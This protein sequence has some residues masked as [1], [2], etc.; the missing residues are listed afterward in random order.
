MKD[1]E[2]LFIQTNGIET[3]FHTKKIQSQVNV[4]HHRIES[5]YHSEMQ[6]FSRSQLLNAN[7]RVVL[8]RPGKRGF[9]FRW[10]ICKIA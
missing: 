4:H 5:L 8:W 9:I 2:H 3:S 7:W 1:M 6:L 10:G